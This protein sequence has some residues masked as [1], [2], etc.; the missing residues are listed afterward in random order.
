MSDPSNLKIK[1]FL[2]GANE[3]DMLAAYKNPLVK[4]FT[5]NPSLMRKAGVKDYEEFARGM[6]E[7]MPDRPISFEVFA[8]EFDEMERQSMEITT[9]GE[10]VY[11]K[12]PITNT[13]SESTVPLIKRLRGEGVKINITALMTV[14]QTRHL[15]DGMG[16]GP[17]SYVSVFAGRSG[18]RGWDPVPMME[19]CLALTN[20][21]EN[22][23]LLWA[24][25]RQ[26]YNIIEADRM[27]CHIITVPGAMIQQLS[28]FGDDMTAHSLETVQIFYDDAMSAGYTL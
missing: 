6:V 27:G 23:E 3:D 21:R 22:A 26:T 9:W 8:D 11:V 16:D 14:E 19:E 20:Q 12:I 18:D 1:I 24:S 13:K 15:I 7:K 4:G 25:T 5:T 17:S 28:K 10:N 2:D